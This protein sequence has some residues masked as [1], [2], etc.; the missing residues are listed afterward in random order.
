MMR[1]KRTRMRG[2]HSARVA[3]GRELDGAGRVIE[4]MSGALL[5]R[6]GDGFGGGL[7]W[8]RNV[9]LLFLRW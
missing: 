5:G 6:F 3:E 1:M 7:L 2:L 8:G 9:L 4:A